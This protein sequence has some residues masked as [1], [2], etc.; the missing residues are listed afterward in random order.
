MVTMI[1]TTEVAMA[2]KAGH[3]GSR[4]G[5]GRPKTDRDDVA[6]KIDRTVV[7]KAKLVASRKGVSL[8]E[9][10][11]ELIRGPVEKGFSQ[12]VREMGAGES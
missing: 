10:V 2:K 6:V 8:A 1:A 4:T 7:D 11:T 5:S 9:Y 3:G 12:A